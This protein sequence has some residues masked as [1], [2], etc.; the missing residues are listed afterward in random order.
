[1]CSSILPSSEWHDWLGFMNTVINRSYDLGYSN[2][3]LLGHRIGRRVIHETIRLDYVDRELPWSVYEQQRD[4]SQ[5]FTSFLG[6]RQTCCF[7]QCCLWFSSLFV[8]LFPFH[9]RYTTIINNCAGVAR[10]CDQNVTGTKR[11]AGERGES[12]NWSC[13]FP[14][15]AFVLLPLLRID[16]CLSLVFALCS[17]L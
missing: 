8:Q 4:I 17:L 6:F 15:F 3:R 1:M 9:Y 12:H 11:R 10:S 5:C 13:L 2:A 14:W 7:A 16:F